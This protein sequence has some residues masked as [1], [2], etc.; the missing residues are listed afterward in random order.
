MCK[1]NTGNKVDP[2]Y[3]EILKKVQEDRLFQ[4]QK[5]YKVDES[6]LLW[7]KDRLY[8]LEGGKNWSSILREFHQEPCLGNPRYQKMISAIKRHFSW[9]MLKSNIAM[10]IVKC[11]E[12]HL[13]KVEHQ[14][15]L[16]LLQSLPI[17][18]WKWEV[19][20]MD[21]ITD[22]LKSK[23]QNYSIFFAHRQVVES[24]T[25]HSCEVNQ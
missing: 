16:R 19:I 12:F 3:V 10:F 5:E 21:F 6:R 11:Q 14:H 1:I 18:K 15:P 7:S 23:K 22:L 25:L 4:Q 17:P 24:S 2:F 9:P 13:V 8:I 20:S